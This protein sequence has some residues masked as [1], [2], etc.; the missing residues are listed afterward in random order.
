MKPKI[1]DQIKPQRMKN[2][3]MYA[4]DSARSI[5]AAVT[6]FRTTKI[7]PTTKKRRRL[8][9]CKFVENLKIVLGKQNSRTEFTIDDF[10][11]AL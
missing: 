8:T 1:A 9:A 4:Q 11:L 3:V 7:N 2:E 6:L 10:W 5:P